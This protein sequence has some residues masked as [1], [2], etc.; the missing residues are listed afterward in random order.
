MKAPKVATLALSVV[1]FFVDGFSGLPSRVMATGVSDPRPTGPSHIEIRSVWATAPPHGD[2]GKPRPTIDVGLRSIEFDRIMGTVPAIERAVPIRES[3]MRIRGPGRAWHGR[4]VGTVHGFAEINRLRMQRGRFLTAADDAGCRNSAV[5]SSGAAEAL[6]PSGDAVGQSV[7]V[8]A[9][10]FRIV[11][12]T[13]QRARD[14]FNPASDRDI[15]VPLNTSKARFGDWIRDERGERTLVFQLS[16]VDFVL[17][18]GAKTQETAS[19]IRSILEP[20]HHRGAVEV[21]VVAPESET[22]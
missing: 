9:E 11:G 8:G 13:M 7:E 5:L 10:S 15:Y 14:R 22:E 6:F 21:I 16:R 18:Q 4:V 20:F 17:R 1:M 12:V 2:V 3:L 19:L